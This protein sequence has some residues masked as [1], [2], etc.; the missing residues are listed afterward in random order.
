MSSTMGAGLRVDHVSLS[1]GLVFDL[2]GGRALAGAE[3]EGRS[4]SEGNEHFT[5]IE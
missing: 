1:F 4:S 5:H 3:S 2:V